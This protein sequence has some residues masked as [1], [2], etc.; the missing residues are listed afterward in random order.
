MTAPPL[1]KRLRP[2]KTPRQARAA[3]TRARILDAA[4]AVFA[5]R[6]YAAG[7]TNRIAQ[8]AGLSVGSLYQYFPNKD[9]ILVELVRAHVD[10]GT[11]RVLAS[12]TDRRG[13]A[14]DDDVESLVR[15]VV[16]AMVEVHARDRRLHRVLFEESPR[17]ASLLAELAELEDQV[18]A[19]LA[20]R[21]AV[22]CPDLD[23][24]SLPARI[25]VITVESLV[26]RMVATD[27][28]LDVDRFVDEAT[29]MV[30]GY[31]HA[32]V[33]APSDRDAARP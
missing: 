31:L 26:H 8:A 32:V 1:E 2:R 21:L 33:S 10:D 3:E 22:W 28:S 30:S 4:R 7:T 16:S 17:P 9:A 19:L 27:R 14:Q 20:E 6:G 18:V 24:S 23:D 15:N 13:V 11:R 12:T 29:R 25:V 5:E